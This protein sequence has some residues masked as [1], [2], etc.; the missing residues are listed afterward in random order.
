VGGS[1]DYDV[2]DLQPLLAGARTM[3]A[4]I[5]TWSNAGYLV[6]VRFDF[7]A[8]TPARKPVKVIPMAWKN[9][10]RLDRDKV[11]YGDPGR[12][13]ASQ[14]PT[15]SVTLPAGG[16]SKSELFVI[17]TGHGQANSDNC[18]EFC[19]REH[20]LLVDGQAHKKTIWRD[21][22]ENNP[23]NN[24]QGTWQYDRAGWC[25]GS[26]VR[27]WIQDLGGALTPG[28]THSIAYDVQA[29]ENT[30]RGSVCTGCYQGVS[31]N[32]DG[33]SHTEP[34]YLVTAFLVLFE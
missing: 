4:Y 13:I 24:Q 27:P 1:W 22:C 8:G 25:P 29:Y 21:D 12:S 17:T 2:T 20:R 18:A 11:V 34:Y 6:T 9:G 16:F 31:C 33:G 28:S 26:N 10:D 3:H 7:K 19:P 32:Y 23:I 30:C 14:L 5:D 15:Q